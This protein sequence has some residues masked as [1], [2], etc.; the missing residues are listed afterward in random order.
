MLNTTDSTSPS[1]TVGAA[2]QPALGYAWY[3]LIVLMICYTLSFIDR[4]ILSLLVGPIKAELGIS[5]KSMALLQG[6]AFA[7]L[8]TTLGVPLGYIAD[9]RSRRLLISIGIFFWSLMTTLTAGARTFTTLFMARVGVGVGEAT[10]APGAFSLI[11]DYFPRHYLG[12]AL[13][14]YAMG[15]FIGAG[16]S[17]LVG[18]WVVQA[19]LA[20]P[21]IDVPVFGLIGSWRLT[22][23][24]VGIPGTGK[25]LTAKATAGVLQLPL[26][27]L[28]VGRLFGGGNGG[29]F[30][31]MRPSGQ[32]GA[33]PG[34][35]CSSVLIIL[36]GIILVCA[37]GLRMLGQ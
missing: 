8:Y 18:G 15:I 28:D 21:P 23:L 4:Q 22:F 29:F 16:M 7:L 1:P 9:T 27:R 17:M 3:A 12:R 31:Q 6:L 2:E 26:L 19:T 37:G 33:W 11:T 35:G 25:S 30:N 13:S 34:C 32:Y 10:L 20:M 36:A 24:I 5:D 14:I